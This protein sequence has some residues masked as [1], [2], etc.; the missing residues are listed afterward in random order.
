MSKLS[1]EAIGVEE[2]N[3]RCKMVLDRRNVYIIGMCLFDCVC[4]EGQSFC[5]RC[6]SAQYEY[7]FV[8]FEGHFV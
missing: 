5:V 1:T 8:S 4:A 3:V 6:R 7:G 2:E